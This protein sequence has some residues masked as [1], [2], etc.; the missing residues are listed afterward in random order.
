MLKILSREVQL[1]QPEVIINLGSLRRNYRYIQDRVGSTKVMAVVKGNAYGHGIREVTS[2]LIDEGIYGFCVALQSE[3]KE[4]LD[5][6]I[7]KPILHL[8]R[9]HPDMLDILSSDMVKCTINSSEDI[10]MLEKYGKSNNIRIQAHLK[11]DTGMTRLGVQPSLI[12][13]CVNN[14]LESKWIELEGL[15]SHFATADEQNSKFLNK[16]LSCFNDYTKQLKEKFDTIKYFHIAPSGAILRFPDTYF[17]MVRPGISLY[18]A[19]PFGNSSNDLE[20]VMEFR[21]PIALIKNINPS[22]AVGYNRTFVSSENMKIALVQG[23]YADGVSTSFSNNGFVSIKNKIIPI[24]GKVAFDLTTIDISSVEC[25]ENDYV[26]FWGGDNPDVRIENI[27]K[28]NSRNP[29][30]LFTSISQRVRR[31]YIDD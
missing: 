26:T 14:L 28:L 21:A 4:L 13:T 24:I 2:T 31:I 5:I 3:V 1:H 8:G 9:I 11:L 27:A 22:T 30:E 20:P 12:K 6:G 10:L 23:G 15:W 7:N 17:N 18:G 16:Q 29:Y 25:E 19:T